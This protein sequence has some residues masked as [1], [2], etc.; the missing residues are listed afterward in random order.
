MIRLHPQR[1]RK[2]IIDRK[3]YYWTDPEGQE[4]HLGTYASEASAKAV[5]TRG[6]APDFR[7]LCIGPYTK[8][9]ATS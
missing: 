3:D 7:A 4:H 8:E 6:L 2:G 9:E 1:P 5:L